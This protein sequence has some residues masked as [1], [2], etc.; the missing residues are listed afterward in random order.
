MTER[1]NR[2]RDAIDSR[3]SQQ[4]VAERLGITRQAVNLR[5][6]GEKDIDSVEFID[7]VSSLT[8]LSREYLITGEKAMVSMALEEGSVSYGMS[9]K[10]EQEFLAGKNIR[11]VMVTVNSS[12]K[13][14]ITYVPVKAQ[15][16]YKRGFGDPSFIETLPAFNLPVNIAGAG[17]FRMFQVDGN[18][19]LQIGGGGLHDGDIVIAEYVEDI[20]TLK[21]NRVY[22]VVSTDGILVKRCINRLKNEENRVLICNSDNKNG[23]YP[24]IVLHPHEILEVWELKAFISRQLSFNTDLWET[25]SELQAQQVMLGEKVKH[26]EQKQLR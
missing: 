18:S 24:A 7:A 9:R 25:L 4:K 2:I 8:G 13:E 12:G 26:L 23:E 19:M 5:L 10:E 15:A 20:F 22:V 6:S 1:N 21:D 11:P 17:T 14:L 16:G 3:S